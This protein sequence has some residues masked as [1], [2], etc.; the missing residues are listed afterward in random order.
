MPITLNIG[1][2]RVRLTCQVKSSTKN[3]YNE[4]DVSWNDDFECWG[5]M[6][7]LKGEEYYAQ[8][9]IKDVQAYRVNIRYQTL[10]DGS[11]ISG[12]CRF[13]VNGST[14]RVLNIQSVADSYERHYELQ[15]ICVEEV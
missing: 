7:P 10:S 13:L 15:M 6:W 5:G 4:D 9:Q 12:N 3:S 2:R 11:R 8:R 14:E 1:A